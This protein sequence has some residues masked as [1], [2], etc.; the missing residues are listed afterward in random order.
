MKVNELKEQKQAPDIIEVEG[1]DRLINRLL[2]TY[3]LTDK[4]VNPDRLKELM[5][6]TYVELNLEEEFDFYETEYNEVIQRYNIRV[7]LNT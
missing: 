5:E 1:V 3:N 7:L 4:M 6:E 2:N